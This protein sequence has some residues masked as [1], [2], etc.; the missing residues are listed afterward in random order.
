M[1]GIG[2][3]VIVAGV[4]FILAIIAIFLSRRKGKSSIDNSVLELLKRDQ[5]DGIEQMRQAMQGQIDAMR[6]EYGDRFADIP[7][8]TLV[9]ELESRM[10]GLNEYVIDEH[11]NSRR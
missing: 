6:T 8:E 10:E 7:S 5:V 2:L 4:S 1:S 9:D 11:Q 3:A